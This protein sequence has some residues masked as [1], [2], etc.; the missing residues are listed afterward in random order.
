MAS[1]SALTQKREPD[2]SEGGR[3]PK[4][5]RI[6]ESLSFE[7]K[8]QAAA[9][10]TQSEGILPPSHVLLG[11]AEPASAPDG[12]LYKILETDVGISEYIARDVPQISGIIKQRYV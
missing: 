9:T 4:R 7:E 12:S 3:S 8:T 2:E 1:E 10:P 11:T 6:D 5:T